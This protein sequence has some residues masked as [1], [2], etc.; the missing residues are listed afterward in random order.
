MLSL[1][2]DTLSYLVPPGPTPRPRA[3]TESNTT[4]G[5]T[6]A[7]PSV[8]GTLLSPIPGSP[9]ADS[10]QELVAK[11]NLTGEDGGG[12]G[13]RGRHCNRHDVIVG[14]VTK[15]HAGAKDNNGVESANAV[16]PTR[17]VDTY[18]DNHHD[19]IAS[20]GAFGDK[21]PG[22]EDVD[23]GEG[24]LQPSAGADSQAGPR[25]GR[26]STRRLSLR[27]IEERLRGRG[28]ERSSSGKE[29]EHV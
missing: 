18:A 15:G 25:R 7:S 20:N 21:E 11:E 6:V 9:L 1:I 8:L 23:G 14:D 29:P 17:V 13:G 19:S 5:V 27:S 26:T 28:S 2:Q 3:Y 22:V 16:G 4:T 12:G 10:R 24:E